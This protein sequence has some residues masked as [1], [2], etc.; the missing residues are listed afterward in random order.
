M[1]VIPLGKPSLWK[2]E[3][4][5]EYD[6]PNCRELLRN[7]SSMEGKLD[8]CPKC[9]KDHLVPP[10]KE[11]PKKDRPLV[12]G[13]LLGIWAIVTIYSIVATCSLFSKTGVDTSALMVLILL[14]AIIIDVLKFVCLIAIER[15]K[16]WGFYGTIGV[17]VLSVIFRAII[18]LK[19]GE[20][21]RAML[22]TMLSGGIFIL[23][24]IVLLH[25]GGSNKVWDQ[26]E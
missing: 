10:G 24:L 3:I 26:M 9:G 20:T 12:L 23:I 18:A 22:E 4:M 16:R 19:S 13:V 2:G 11:M 5:I 6:C 17:V 21:D 14:L 25:I 8:F 7:K 1:L 15:Y